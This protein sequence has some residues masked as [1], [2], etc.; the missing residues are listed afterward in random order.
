MAK[1]RGAVAAA[2]RPRRHTVRL[3]APAAKSVVVTGSF[4]GWSPGGHP[5]GRD[6]RGV[7]QAVLTLPPGRYEYRFV[8]DGQWRDDPACA[9][10]VANPFGSENGVFVV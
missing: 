10:R 5:L 8:V 4:C 6:A 3:E 9:D 7:W 1:H 2:A